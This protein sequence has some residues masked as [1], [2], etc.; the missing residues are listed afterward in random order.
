[1]VGLALSDHYFWVIRSRR[2]E[3]GSYLV[4]I[5]LLHDCTDEYKLRVYLVQA[6]IRQSLDWNVFTR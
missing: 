6:E 3:S 2:G 1:M 5:N 4:S